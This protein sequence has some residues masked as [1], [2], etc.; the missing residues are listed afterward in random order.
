M[1]SRKQLTKLAGQLVTPSA[2]SDNRSG[3]TL[4]VVMVLLTLMAVL[5][6]F[7]YRMANTQQA[8]AEYFA[9]TPT[10]K[11]REASVDSAALFDWAL[12]QIIKG[13]PDSLPNSALGGGRHGLVPNMFGSDIHPYSGSGYNVIYQSDGT[14]TDGTLE[15][16]NNLD[17]TAE[18]NT[19]PWYNAS[20]AANGGNADLFAAGFAPDANYTAP[21]LNNLY[22][23]HRGYALDANNN[24]V[25]V[26]KPSYHYPPALRHSTDGKIYPYW[27]KES[28]TYPNSDPALSLR[29]HEDHQYI[30]STN[31]AIANRFIRA[32]ETVP[33]ITNPFPF[34]DVTNPSLWSEGVWGWDSTDWTPGTQPTYVYDADADGDGI[35]EALYVDLDFPLQTTT[36]G[37]ETFLPIYGITIYDADGLINLNAHGNIAGDLNLGSTDI[38]SGE[39]ISRSNLGVSASEVD[40]TWVLNA[41]PTTATGTELQ[42]H[43]WFYGHLPTDTIETANMEWFFANVGRMHFSQSPTGL[44]DVESYYQGRYGDQD[45]EEQRLDDGWLSDD[46]FQYPQP[47]V[48]GTD[49][50]ANSAVALPH[51]SLSGTFSY[52]S[53]DNLPLHPTDYIGTGN[54]HAA[55]GKILNFHNDGLLNYLVYM[56]YT[57]PSQNGWYSG[58]G[59]TL[60]T[61]TLEI[62]LTA[63]G[64]TDEH[65]EMELDPRLQSEEDNDAQFSPVES[66]PM[67]MSNTD[68]ALSSASSR[69]QSLMPWNLR[70]N[71]RAEEIRQNFTTHSMDLKTRGIN[72]HGD[73]GPAVTRPWEFSLVGSN[74]EFPPQPTTGIDPFR[75]ALRA[76]LKVVAGNQNNVYDTGELVQRLLSLNHV[77]DI[78]GSTPYLRRLTPHPTGLDETVVTS[79]S[80]DTII[81]Q[82]YQARLDRQKMARDIYVLLYVF[83]DEGTTNPLVTNPYTDAEIEEMAQFAINVVNQLDRDNVLDMF[84]F[85]TDLTDGWEVDDNPYDDTADADP[86]D[87]GLVYGVEAQEL[88]LNEIYS[89]FTDIVFD[90]SGNTGDANKI[91]LIATQ[92]DDTEQQSFFYVELQN[93]MP[94]AVPLGNDT[95]NPSISDNGAWRLKITSTVAGVPTDEYLTI[96]KPTD[97]PQGANWSILSSSSYASTTPVDSGMWLDIGYPADPMDPM[98]PTSLS[99]EA[100]TDLIAPLNSIANWFDLTA[101]APTVAAT[102]P[103]D[104]YNYVLSDGTSRLGEASIGVGS[105]AQ[106]YVFETVLGTGTAIDMNDLTDI[107]VSL[108]RRVHTGR[109]IDNADVT[110]ADAGPDNPWVTIDEMSLTTGNGIFKMDLYDYFQTNGISQTETMDGTAIRDA[111]VAEMDTKNGNSQ[112]RLEA[113]DRFDVGIY[114]DSANAVDSMIFHTVGAT[115]SN[116]PA[117]GS[118]QI[119]QPHFN[120]DFSSPIELLSVPLYG[121]DVLTDSSDEEPETGSD[122]PETDYDDRVRRDSGLFLSSSGTVMAGHNTAGLVKFLDVPGDATN[123]NSWYRLLAFFEVPRAERNIDNPNE[124]NN[125][126]RYRLAG[127]INWNTV[128]SPEVLAAL[129]DEI[130]YFNQLKLHD[131]AHPTVYLEDAT[132]NSSPNDR[133]W[134][135]Q[136]I[137]ARDQVTYDASGASTIGPDPI[138]DM[139]LPGMPGSRPF[140]TFDHLANTTDGGR[141]DTMLR[142]LPMD[143][144]AVSPPRTL[145]EVG[146]QTEHSS[147][148]I[149]YLTRNK[150]LAKILNNSTTRSNVFFV[151]IQVDFFEAVEDGGAVR[152]GGKRDDSPG[153]RELFVIDRSLAFEELEQED[154]PT[155]PNERF[156]IGET[157]D[158]RKL[159]IARFPIK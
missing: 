45:S 102:D 30:D 98:A 37:S 72:Y 135:V 57:F 118:Y 116:T 122:L 43:N 41:D 47:G 44:D 75:P 151:F 29:A 3:A 65:L 16:D 94:M 80:G 36:D 91:D 112:E 119:W 38:G 125:P 93:L 115:N 81:E 113:L 145:F 56:N 134:W 126:E 154:F 71:A 77:L 82:E 60:S 156:T 18:A 131:P 99:F 67:Q 130:D 106:P 88:T 147:N 8:S 86:A 52:Y 78:D 107:K 121:P 124:L 55:G 12:E 110:A 114:D 152:V 84:E 7:A 158:W 5:G 25:L 129:L 23:A 95:T 48:A 20:R 140:R 11:Y 128:R 22:L 159:V 143:V 74:Y 87:R 73:T 138:T 46:R 54:I 9:N 10:A 26:I 141:Q 32:T 59:A 61:D 136:F 28:A 120:R 153:F 100:A 101:E 96:R 111:V 127:K 50:N 53:Y 89:V 90:D 142:D 69:L 157:F 103:D 33:G 1:K 14:D 79:A 31:T 132:E 85:D 49:D 109:G 6:Y 149:D 68:I 13:A 27:F 133:D 150:L 58:L 97:I 63:N 139:Y 17:G 51:G 35:K 148:S 24:K 83:C 155:D 137:R 42:Q 70:D 108:Q 123:E 40:P 19:D 34:P 66:A 117:A 62:D 144:G 76:W 15:F 105:P 64:L 39:S 4:I 2:Q 21:D 92:W 146:N 104:S